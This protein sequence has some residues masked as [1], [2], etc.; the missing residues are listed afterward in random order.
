MMQS[1][2][3]RRAHLRNIALLVLSAVVT[4]PVAG[5]KPARVL[6]PTPNIYVKQGAAPFAEVPAVNRTS[7]VEL[8]YVTDRQPVEEDGQLRYGYQRSPS[9]AVGLCRVLIGEDVTWEKLVGQ[10]ITSSRDIRLPVRVDQIDEWDRFPATP[11]P[12][13]RV[14]DRF[15][16]DPQILAQIEDARQRLWP[17]IRE[18]LANVP[19]KEIFVFVHGYNNTFDDAATRMAE[20]WH[21]LG[22]PGL[23]MIYT[24]PAG[25]GGL[26]GY[27]HDRESG[28]FTVFHLKQ[29]L[30]ALGS[31][32]EVERVHILAHSRGTDVVTSALRELLIEIRAGD[33]DVQGT[34]KIGNLVLAA[35]DLD[36]EVLSQR[37]TAERVAM[38]PQRLTIYIS[39]EDK[40]IGLA[41]WLYGSIRRF[42]QLRLEDLN[43]RQQEQL[44]IM[45]G[46]DVIDARVRKSGVGHGYFHS[47]PA[48]S[49]DLILIFRDD[50]DPGAENG[51]PLILKAPNFWVIQDDYP[52]FE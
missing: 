45:E 18:R 16:E 14:N 36:I 8:L 40:A 44:A 23:A 25:R 13:I 43:A 6:M 35:P 4:I 51:R 29:F 11:V 33:G 9:I 31:Y 39:K 37:I 28:E 7:H 47:S 19:R 3:K 15:Q 42:G 21:F 20:L 27:F 22:R 26:R 17:K 30:R 41:D 1:M 12:L 34:L 50:R 24:W 10:S 49:S 2:K 5:C 32:P 52:V 46:L 48:V 38:V